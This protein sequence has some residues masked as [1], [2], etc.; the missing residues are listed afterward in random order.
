VTGAGD[1]DLV[2]VGSCGIPPF[3]VRVDGSVFCGYQHP[4]WF[5]SPRS[6]GD[7]SLKI[8]SEVGH[9]RSRH[10]SS[11]LC[12]QV[13]CEVFMKL[14]EIAQSAPPSKTLW[15]PSETGSEHLHVIAEEV[16]RV[17][18]LC[19]GQDMGTMGTATAFMQVEAG[20]V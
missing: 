10:E 8:A 16:S 20:S 5:A 11:L 2:A 17:A 3:G 1:F 9:L 15:A 12:R 19:I 7:D 4:A 13:C 14:R 6:R 18:E